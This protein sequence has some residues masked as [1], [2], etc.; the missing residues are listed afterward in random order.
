MV[1]KAESQRSRILFGTALL[2]PGQG[3]I[4]R[5]ARMAARALV[6]SGAEVD[7]VSYL[8]EERTEIAGRR[9][10]LAHGD[11]LRYALLTQY[12]AMRADFA[13]YD[14]VGLARGHPRLFRADLPHGLW[15]MG[16]ESWE[17]MRADHLACA[18]RADLAIAI[19]HC[20]LARHQAAHGPLP[21]AKVCWLAT[22]QDDPPQSLAQFDGPPTVLI[23]ARIARQEGRKGH[24]EL[25]QCWPQVVAAV[26][27]ARLVVVGDGD[28][29]PA[30]KAKV[31][32]SPARASIE[33]RGHVAEDALPGLFASAHVYAMPSRQEGFG[34]VYAEA[35]RFG[36][37]LIVSDSDA[38]QEI[39]VD[40]ETGFT[41][42]AA[43]APALAE[44]LIALLRQPDLCARMGR[45]GFE[46]WRENFRYSCFA[47]RFLKIWGDF[48]QSA[49][50]RRG[51]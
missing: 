13:L 44:A 26:P 38:G 29:L 7:V 51:R 46:R 27:R 6:E 19:S 35:M 40:G 48:T 30:L 49:C 42:P 3:G 23:L 34:I 43:N 22:E 9:A 20:T 47:G 4:A 8:D 17:G 21:Q 39:N 18:R 2:A 41:V 36:L 24:D 11:K 28:G 1:A 32:A 31:A 45:A 5:V 33:F 14:S 15:L 25:V 50:R 10:R 16:T 12:F 37:P